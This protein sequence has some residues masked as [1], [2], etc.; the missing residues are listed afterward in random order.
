MTA[1]PRVSV[2][3]LVGSA[4]DNFHAELSRLYARACLDAL[5]DRYDVLLAYVSPDGSWRFPDDLTAVALSSATAVPISQAITH[6][7]SLRV[8]VVVPQ[9]FCLPGMTS[10]RR[11]LSALRLPYIGNPPEVMEIA[12]D[13]ATARS[14]VAQA[15]VAVPNG[16]VVRAAE[17]TTLP[18]PVVVKPVCADNSVGVSLVRAPAQLRPAIDLARQHGGAAL[19]ESYVA[20][21]REVR[22]GIVVRDGELVCLPLEEYAVDASTK[23][24]RDQTDKLRRTDRG[25]LYLVAKDPRHAWIVPTDDPITEAVWE[26]ARRCHRALGCRHYGLFDFRIDPDGKPWFLEAGPYC[27]F[28][29][30]SVIAVMAAAAGIDVAE[31]FADQLREIGLEEA[32]C[33]TAQ[34]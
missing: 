20:L 26:V 2:L 23:P 4:V 18:L 34:G 3:H 7:R 30:T 22:C 14:I 21:G 12:A 25:D 10:Y 15:G 6:L 8:D 16:E 9:M 31:L 1:P 19:V 13:K 17:Q 32:P 33:L 24:I 29:P 28:A 11:L 27:S 5:A